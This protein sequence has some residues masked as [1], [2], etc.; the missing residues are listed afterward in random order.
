[1]VAVFF[2]IIKQSNQTIA[3]CKT[4]RNTC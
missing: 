1:M 3:T 2:A 4:A